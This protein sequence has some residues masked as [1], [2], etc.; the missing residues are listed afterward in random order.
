MAT[1]AEKNFAENER[2]LLICSGDFTEEAKNKFFP[3]FQNDENLKM[4]IEQSHRFLIE[5]FE[6]CMK[7]DII[8]QSA[9]QI[10]QSVIEETTIEEYT[11]EVY[12]ILCRIAI[13]EGIKEDVT[14]LEQF[15]NES[16]LLAKTEYISICIQMINSQE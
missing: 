14:S 15:Y 13:L 11:N 9:R 16:I 2:I 4:D 10:I 6:E 3:K 5:Y 1:E 12:E 8:D 7:L